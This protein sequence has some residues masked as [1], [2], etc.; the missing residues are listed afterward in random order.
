MNIYHKEKQIRCKA[1][2]NSNLKLREILSN[3]K[4]NKTWNNT[5]LNNFLNRRAPFY[6]II[7]KNQ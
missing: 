5:S 4:L 1:K 2:R 6:R 3:K 7:K